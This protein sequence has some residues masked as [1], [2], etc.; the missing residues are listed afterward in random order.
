MTTHLSMEQLLAVRDGD[1]SEPVLA[2]A[3]RHL[4]DCATCQAELNR[5]HQRTARLRALAAHDAGPRT[6]F[7]PP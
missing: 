6:G 4:A 1:R 3:H 5:L 7:P 2:G